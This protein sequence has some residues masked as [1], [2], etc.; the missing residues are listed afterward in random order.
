MR[1]ATAAVAITLVTLIGLGATLTITIPHTAMDSMQYVEENITVNDTIVWGCPLD[2]FIPHE[3]S[4]GISEADFRHSM[5]RD[6]LRIG[7][8]F[9]KNQT[10]FIE[11][12]DPFV[13]RVADHISSLF[14][15]D[16]WVDAALYF[17]QSSI[18]YVSDPE[19]YG[20]KEFISFPLETLYLQK[21]DCED[22]SI[23]LCSIYEALGIRSAL[24]NYVGHVAVGV[25]VGENDDYLFCETTFNWCV[26]PSEH[27]FGVEG[28][29]EVHSYGEFHVGEY[30][31]D[32]IA[33]YRNLI[34]RV[35]GTLFP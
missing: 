7:T 24:L 12:D 22:T 28:E 29:P 20:A 4:L 10:R 23:L 5:S 18:Q 14:P 33:W 16:E 17:V 19:L 2:G 26:P 6:V 21:G 13:K 32:G 8:L 15:E 30:L 35:T 34:D 27:Q 31:N 3:L 11:P 9:D 1:N 25:F